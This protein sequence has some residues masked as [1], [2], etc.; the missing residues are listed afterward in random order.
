MVTMKYTMRPT[1]QPEM[2][3]IFSELHTTQPP[4]R[5]AKTPIWKLNYLEKTLCSFLS[6]TVLSILFC[7]YRAMFQSILLIYFSDF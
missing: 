7:S 4:K 2:T 6:N 5:K 3:L 1:K